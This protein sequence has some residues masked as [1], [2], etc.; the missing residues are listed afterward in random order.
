MNR[1]RFLSTTAAATAG[2]AAALPSRSYAQM[3]PNETINVAI[4]GIR[5]DNAGR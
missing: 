1:R 3:S 4:I 5:G 2:M